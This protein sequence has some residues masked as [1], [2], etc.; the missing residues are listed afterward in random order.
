MRLIKLL[1]YYRHI[2][3]PSADIILLLL[4]YRSL[5]C[6]YM[7]KESFVISPWNYRFYLEMPYVRLRVLIPKMLVN[8]VNVSKRA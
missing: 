3:T 5:V 2:A 7:L 8:V 6:L 4:I 1:L